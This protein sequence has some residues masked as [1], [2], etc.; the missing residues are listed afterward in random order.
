MGRAALVDGDANALKILQRVTQPPGDC[1]L[2]IWEHHVGWRANAG[3]RAL[4]RLGLRRRERQPIGSERLVH[5]RE[6]LGLQPVLLEAR[7]RGEE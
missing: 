4:G 7:K 3:R 2:R 6:R 5:R 1:E